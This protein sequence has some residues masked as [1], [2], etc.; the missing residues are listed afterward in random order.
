MVIH[1]AS[2]VIHDLLFLV[3][4]LCRLTAWK[5][6]SRLIQVQL[7]ISMAPNMWD[8]LRQRSVVP[9]TLICY[10]YNVFKQL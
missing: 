4:F 7:R 1:G 5:R 6:G 2:L 8:G 10:S 9:T 3:L